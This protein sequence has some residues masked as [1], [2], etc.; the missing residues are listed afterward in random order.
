MGD[1]ILN[2]P[3]V[4]SWV[5]RSGVPFAIICVLSYVVL[6]ILKWIGDNIVIKFL[7]ELIGSI[8]DIKESNRQVVT[9]L[10][11]LVSIQEVNQTSIKN[12]IALTE[13][14]N[15]LIS[16]KSL[17]K[18]RKSVIIPKTTEL[19]NANEPQPVSSN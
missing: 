10:N 14:T 13:E 11:N 15:Q 17:L 9:G 18:D 3:A 1:L 5:E 19:I 16:S 4:L 12:L 8:K 2:F 6:K 7:N